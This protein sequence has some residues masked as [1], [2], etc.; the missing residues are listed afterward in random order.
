MLACLDT[1]KMGVNQEELEERIFL[2]FNELRDKYLDK[3]F[4]IFVVIGLDL[5]NEKHKATVVYPMKGVD[6]FEGE[7]LNVFNDESIDALYAC[8]V[9]ESHDG[10]ILIDENGNVIQNDTGLI[11]DI[12][13]DIK[14]I[15][16]RYFK[17]PELAVNLPYYEQLGFDEVVGSKHVTAKCISYELGVKVLTLSQETGHIRVFDNGYTV[18]SDVSSEIEEVP[19]FEDRHHYS[20]P[21]RNLIRQVS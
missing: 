10:A 15:R 7:E 11:I 18:Y 4:G 19:I 1:M 6:Y 3:K 2:L 17:N 14:E 12:M 9:G 8:A 16:Q 20:I 13:H 5:N 21:G